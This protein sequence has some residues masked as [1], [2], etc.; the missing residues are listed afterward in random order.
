ME[1]FTM[2]FKHFRQGVILLI[3]VSLALSSVLSVAAQ[4]EDEDILVEIVGEVE[5][6]DD[7]EIVIAG[8]TVAPAGAF[9][10]SSLEVGDVVRLTGYLLDD[11]TLKA[12]EL[13]MVVDFDE[14][15]VLDTED[16][17]PEV[18]NPGQE[19]VDEDGVGDACDPDLIDTD[20][21]GV[22]DAEDNCPEIENPE[23]EDTDEDGVGD[24]CSVEEEDASDMGDD[25]VCATADPHPV[26]MAIAEEFGIDYETVIAWHCGEAVENGRVGFGNIT[27]ALLLA[28]QLGVTPEELFARARSEGWG[29]IKREAK[30]LTEGF[31]ISV[32]KDKD[33]VPPGQDP[34]RVPPGQDP[35]RVPPGQDPD[36]EQGN[37]GN[38]G[39]GGNN[40]KGKDK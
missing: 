23:Q 38:N 7:E 1:V 11:D 6:I 30:Q 16:N 28:E 33:K 26:G 17:C 21:D 4:D 37:S 31:T 18:E 36:R 13:E 39:N 12:V 19:D 35:D 32:G 40:G 3:F 10:P 2:N 24:A 9:N 8:V 14:D 27:R 5:V 15:G 22:V 20:E 34:D 29:N 25:E